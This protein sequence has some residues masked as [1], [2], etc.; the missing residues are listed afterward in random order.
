[1]RL[2]RCHEFHSHVCLLSWAGV[3]FHSFPE[4]FLSGGDHTM[5]MIPK[6]F[7]SWGKEFWQFSRL[8]SDQSYAP[9][10]IQTR[11]KLCFYYCEMKLR[12]GERL[13]MKLF[14]W[15]RILSPWEFMTEFTKL[16]NHNS[17]LLLFLAHIHEIEIMGNKFWTGYP[18][19]SFLLL[20]PVNGDDSIALNVISLSANCWLA[21]MLSH[22]HWN[23][24]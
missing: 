24:F 11:W 2:Q 6:T 3:R 12:E 8:V 10:V 16:H 21:L 13:E 20:L 1:M 4:A 15:S 22:W 5:R 18:F 7:F 23:V 19:A 17:S 14:P 9:N